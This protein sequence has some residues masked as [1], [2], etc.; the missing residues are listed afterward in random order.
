MLVDNLGD[1]LERGSPLSAY[2]YRSMEGKLRGG[3]IGD[4]V[5]WAS[6]D[7]AKRANVPLCRP[8]NLR[9]EAA[10]SQTPASRRAAVL[11]FANLRAHPSAALLPLRTRENTAKTARQWGP[12]KPGQ[13]LFAAIPVRYRS[14]ACCDSTRLDWTWVN[15]IERTGPCVPYGAAANTQQHAAGTLSYR[16]FATMRQSA[17]FSAPLLSSPRSSQHCMP[18]T[19]LVR[20]AG[21]IVDQPSW[22]SSVD[23][24]LTAKAVCR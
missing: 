6:P 14:S 12:A 10:R 11:C 23:V 22:A 17:V 8:I 7:T 9:I 21:V 2:L 13:R 19:P 3:V 1:L 4:R 20:C 16:V 18:S 5:Y 15:R 24:C